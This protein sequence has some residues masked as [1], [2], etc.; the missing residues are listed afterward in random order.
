MQGALSANRICT[1]TPEIS[2]SRR[3]WYWKNLI[4]PL[5]L[6]AVLLA[7]AIPNLELFISLF[8][9]LCLSAL[10]I[11][12]PAIIETATFWYSTSRS[13]SFYSMLARNTFLVIF[14]LFG[15]VVGTYTSLSGIIHT[16][17]T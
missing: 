1:G 6:F 4:F 5:A 8:G 9:A 13:S 12:F 3:P 2:K 7:V 11:A 17:F 10:G 16:F 14:S 15:L